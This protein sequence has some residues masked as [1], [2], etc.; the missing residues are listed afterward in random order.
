MNAVARLPLDV[1]EQVPLGRF[2]SLKVGGPARRFFTSDDVTEVA[3]LLEAAVQDDARILVLGGG[4]NLLFSD[5]GFDGVVV[6]YTATGHRIETEPDDSLTRPLG[7]DLRRQELARSGRRRGV[8]GQRPVSPPIRVE[9]RDELVPGERCHGM[10]ER[11]QDARPEVE[12]RR[13]P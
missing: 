6:R 8:P 10:L 1:A 3:R 5:E 12:A 2:T 13:A 7:D 11:P 4:T 9:M